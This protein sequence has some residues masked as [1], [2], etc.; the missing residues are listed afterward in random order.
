MKKD[1]LFLCEWFDPTPYKLVEVRRR[2]RYRKYDLFIIAQQVRQDK[3]N[4]WIVSKTKTSGGV[5]VEDSPKVAYQNDMLLPVDT[6]M[7]DE[8]CENPLDHSNPIEA[9]SDDVEDEV[10]LVEDKDELGDKETSES[11]NSAG[12]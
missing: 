12:D 4:W 5:E 3:F 8:L 9:I 10:E 1:V 2:G 7:L 11:G 6:I